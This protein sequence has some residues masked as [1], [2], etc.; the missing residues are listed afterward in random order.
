[1]TLAKARTAELA[2]FVGV[3]GLNTVLT[4]AAFYA[5]SYVMVAA[6]AFTL[7]YVAGIAFVMRVT[8]HFVF[9]TSPSRTR[10][11]ALGLW[12]ILIYLCGLATSAALDHATDSRELVVAG[13]LCVTVPL[14]FV[15]SRTV[16]SAGSR[17]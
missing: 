12:Y 11:A 7:A 2:R 16:L 9:R 1:M 8:P 10:R 15:G 13:T 17:G 6:A 14:G 5:L 4:T 3:G